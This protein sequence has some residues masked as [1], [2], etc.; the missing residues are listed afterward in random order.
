MT[1]TIVS[2]ALDAISQEVLTLLP[3]DEAVL[4][5][6]IVGKLGLYVDY[7]DS[8]RDGLLAGGILYRLVHR[9]LVEKSYKKLSYIKASGRLARKNRAHYRRIDKTEG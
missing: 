3:Y 6:E 7:G 5:D 8:G 2:A 4:P 9:G 1:N